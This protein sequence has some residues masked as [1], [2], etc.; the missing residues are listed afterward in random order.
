M[1]GFSDGWMGRSKRISEDATWR[2]YILIFFIF[3]SFNFRRDLVSR[4]N[5]PDFHA[6]AGRVRQMA[7]RRA[8]VRVSLHQSV[9]TSRNYIAGTSRMRGAFFSFLFWPDLEPR[10]KRGAQLFPVFFMSEIFREDRLNFFWTDGNQEAIKER[11]RTQEINIIGYSG[12]SI[13]IWCTRLSTG[14]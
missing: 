11:S 5:S 9:S 3:S 2:H 1:N 4:R 12:P 8:A 10:Y 6:C 14:L 13:Q 7:A